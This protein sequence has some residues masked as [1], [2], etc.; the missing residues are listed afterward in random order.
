[1]GECHTMNGRTYTDYN[2]IRKKVD[3]V[4]PTLGTVIGET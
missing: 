4:I 1:M 2:N 3:N